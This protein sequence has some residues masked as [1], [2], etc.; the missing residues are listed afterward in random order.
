MPDIVN[1]HM[2]VSRTHNGYMKNFPS[3][4]PTKEKKALRKKRCPWSQLL[5]SG[6]TVQMHMCP[7]SKLIHLINKY[8]LSANYELSILLSPGDTSHK[9]VGMAPICKELTVKE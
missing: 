9:Q 7:N 3:H 6:M 1:F 4:L 2:C 8:L 5:S